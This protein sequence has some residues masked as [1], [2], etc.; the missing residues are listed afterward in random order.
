[1]PGPAA[2]RTAKAKRL[3]VI[4]ADLGV[5]KTVALTLTDST[6]E[7]LSQLDA[8]QTGHAVRIPS[9]ATKA[10]VLVWMPIADEDLAEAEDLLENA[11]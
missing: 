5:S 7:T 4:L 8:A 10:E 3:A 1:M 9:A 6:W 11:F 2:N